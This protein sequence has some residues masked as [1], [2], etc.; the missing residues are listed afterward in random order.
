M[1]HQRA[2]DAAGRGEELA[3]AS[4]LPC[5]LIAAETSVSLRRWVFFLSL[6]FCFVLL[7]SEFQEQVSVTGIFSECYDFHSSSN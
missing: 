7:V 3:A 2:T 5:G 1:R 6:L 4:S